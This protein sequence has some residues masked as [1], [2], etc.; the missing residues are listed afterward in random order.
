MPDRPL[1]LPIEVQAR[2]SRGPGLPARPKPLVPPACVRRQWPIPARIGRSRR[3]GAERRRPRA[4][5]R[6]ARQR[7]RPRT[8]LVQPVLRPK[9]CQSFEP[10]SERAAL[11]LAWAR[12]SPRRMH[13]AQETPL[14]VE[15]LAQPKVAASPTG[16]SPGRAG[17]TWAK[18]AAVWQAGWGAPRWLWLAIAPGSAWPRSA[19]L[20][21][22][23][24]PRLMQPRER[25]PPW[26]VLL[27][28]S[29]PA[30]PSMQVL[31]R[32]QC[33]LRLSHR[34]TAPCQPRRSGRSFRTCG[35]IPRDSRQSWFSSGLGV[36]RAPAA[37]SINVRS[38]EQVGINEALSDAVSVA[39]ANLVN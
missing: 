16:F 21:R 8:A 20:R 5:A 9:S 33:S 18:A 30:F 14:I 31:P 1:R 34:K 23:C 7:P 25:I 10:R 37:G 11:R 6:F 12:S 15:G 17:P 27:L 39:H 24:F 32:R 28:R 19:L 4:T 3:C 22:L 38:S 29:P 26:S 35:R 13:P 36:A 2:F